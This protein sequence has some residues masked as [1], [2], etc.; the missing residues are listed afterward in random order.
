MFEKLQEGGVLRLRGGSSRMSEVHARTVPRVAVD[1]LSAG[2]WVRV[3][4]SI[5]NRN[6]YGVRNNK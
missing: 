3:R 4:Q 1:F 5:K 2:H 6:W